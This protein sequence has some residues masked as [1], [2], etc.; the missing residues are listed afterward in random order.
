M[1][2]K[3]CFLGTP[4]LLID[5]VPHLF[6]FKKA[7]I[8]VLIIIEEKSMSRDK[9]CEL[10]WADKPLEKARRNLSNAISYI[11]KIMPVD[12]TSGSIISLAPKFKIEK[13][14]DAIL[15]IDSMPPNKI[16][17][18]SL[19]FMNSAELEDWPSFADWLM[20]KRQHYHDLF[21][22]ELKKR[23]QKYTDEMSEEGYE[24]A[25][26]CYEFLA[27]MEPYD[28]KINGELVRL[29]IKTNQKVKAIASA[30]TFSK[31]I[32]NDF[33]IKADLSDISSLMA[34]NSKESNPL[35]CS[36]S[37]ADNPLARNREIMQ[38]LD[39]IE[40]TGTD[41]ISSCGF[42]WGE[43]GIGKTVFINEIISFLGERNWK[44]SFV[45]CN[46]E[47][48][49]CSMACFMRFL[50]N[51]KNVPEQYGDITAFNELNYALIAK[52]VYD[53][54]TDISRNSNGLLVIENIQW[55]DNASW[56]I[57]E[58]I[59]KDHSAVRHILVT[60]FEEVR[61][62]F[63][64]RVNTQDEQFE[65]LE[66]LL[67]RF[68]LEE[69]R[70]ICNETCPDQEWTDKKVREVYMQTEGN[71]FFIKETLKFND[72]HNRGEIGS[73]KN[74]FLSM[75]ELLNDEERLF[76]EAIAASFDY[77]PMT[78]IARVLEISPLQV[79]KLYNNVRIHGFLREQSADEGDILYYFTHTKIKEAVITTMSLSRRQ[80][81]HLKYIEILEEMRIGNFYRHRGTCSRLFMHCHEANLNMKELYWRIKELELHF[82]AAH[83]VFPMLID[84]D[85]MYYVPSAEDISYTE[86]ALG[87]AM[88]LLDKVSREHGGT[89]EV[90]NA[91]TD[92]FTLN[93]AYLW[94]NGHYSD[95]RQMLN[96]ALRK[97]M[98]NKGG[99]SIL[100]AAVQICY[101]AI[102][103]DDAKLLSKTAAMVF[104]TAQ[105]EHRH[106]LLGI[107]ARFLAISRILDNRHDEVHRLL[108]MS[109]KIFETLEE[110]G[111]R[112]TVSIIAAEHFRGDLKLADG[113]I[114]E[115]LVY[116]MNCIN[117][118]ESIGLYR[119]LGLSL[120]KAAF[121]MMLLRDYE[122]A[123]KYLLRTEKSFT[124]MHSDSEEGLQG[125]GIAFSLMGLIYCRNGDWNQGKIY[126]SMAQRLVK[127]TKRPTWRAM[128]YWAKLR[129]YDISSE[130]P[131]DFAKT[132]LD[133]GQKY[134]LLQMHKLRH[135]VGWIA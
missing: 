113:M 124:M 111:E 127:N 99:T 73:Y 88:E 74:I 7:Q 128:L 108:Q 78:Q 15:K 81:L 92:L 10:L 71:P 58:S 109:T 44:C 52:L 49:D 59:I 16:A 14:T 26:T 12:I 70:R 21:I 20:Q 50:Q 35:F 17:E 93:G 57:L 43:Q 110:R 98:I 30:R 72:A 37:S 28:E 131:D 97:A 9:L 89:P 32:E 135:Q 133:R 80:A 125:G 4:E 101:L 54:I 56:M 8:L 33:G 24:N 102:Q 41:K 84:Q 13:D 114:A 132:V 100:K 23:A 25:V 106:P 117:I 103:T 76:V 91:E 64:L 60:G 120:A 82:R 62:S 1:K 85:L 96:E 95:S 61:S 68:N 34:R 66:I 45:R 129:L 122:T 79:S 47:E 123:E 87:E 86:K 51:I 121:C 104:R 107:S 48:K 115:A 134:Y 75:V 38:M 6:P 83:E 40:R 90:L 77:A 130:I 11:K 65:Q 29:Y 31:R 119:G 53:E 22:K 55:M 105:K 112:Y 46:Q 126:F 116:Y 5:G 94:W 39:F 36:A 19:P 18:L 27:E 2:F 67:K 42:V 118:G 3:A 69:T 63:M